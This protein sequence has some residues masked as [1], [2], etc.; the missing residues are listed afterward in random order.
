MD[1]IE[2]QKQIQQMINFILNEAKDKANE[3]E[4]K[5]L[6]DFN[7]EKLKLVQSYKEQIRQDLK[8]KVKRLEVER[9]IARSTAI[10]KAR[11]KKMA[12]RA[13]VLTEV[14]QQTRKKMC[15]ISTNPTVYE[16]LLV[17]LL[18]QAMLKLLEPT[19]IVKCRKSD[20]SVVESAIPKAIK[21]YKEILQKECG[22]S[23]NVEAKVDKENFLFPAPTSVE[24]NSKYC[25]GGVMVTNLDGKIV[26][27]NTLDARL[28][29]VIQN[30][31]P[32]I[33]STLFPKAA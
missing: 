26:C 19:V 29:L 2:A 30:D 11:L 16:P 18:T 17:D 31:A 10:N 4:A 12:A 9:A 13:Q 27:N 14:V 20:V 7:I 23:M 33:R 1:D 21:K 32:I 3:I 25:S 8:K 22:V 5:A 28:D 24:Q 6:Q 15:E